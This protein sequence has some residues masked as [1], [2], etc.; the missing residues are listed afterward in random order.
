[1][2]HFKTAEHLCS[3]AGLSPGNNESAGKKK[4]A[5]I[6][7]GNP[8]VKSMLCEVAWIIAGKRNL[9]LSRWYWRI[10]QKKGAKKAIIALARKLLVIIYTMLRNG[11]FF[12][13]MLFES[14]RASA[15]QQRTKRYIHELEKLGYKIELQQA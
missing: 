6:T 5:R 1:M 9:Y 4:S 11:T 3:W 10:K 13:E 7:K 15:E 14:R 8:Y 12:D 2:S